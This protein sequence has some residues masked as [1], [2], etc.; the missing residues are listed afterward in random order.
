PPFLPLD[1]LAAERKDLVAD[2]TTDFL[3]A[4]ADVFFLD[5]FPAAFLEA[6]ERVFEVEVFRPLEA[7]RPLVAAILVSP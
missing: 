4:L 7:F 2:L 1:F 5:F 3:E 6:A